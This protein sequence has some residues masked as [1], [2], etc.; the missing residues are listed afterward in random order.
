MGS[1]QSAAPTSNGE[2]AIEAVDIEAVDIEA[3]PA[4][5]W[6]AAVAGGD[7]INQARGA[8]HSAPSTCCSL[9]ELWSAA[10]SAKAAHHAK[11]VTTTTM[12]AHAPIMAR[13]QAAQST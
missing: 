13:R 1:S 9:V 6:A 2:E 5:A 3:A 7:V 10:P 8:S 4:P 12:K 11:E